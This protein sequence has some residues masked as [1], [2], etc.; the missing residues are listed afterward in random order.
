MSSTAAAHG[1]VAPPPRRVVVTGGSGGIGREIVRRFVD[2]GCEVVNLDRLPPPAPP[3]A[4]GTGGGSS[5]FIGVDLLDVEAIRA[6]FR[7]ADAHFQGLAPDVL[8]CGAAIGLTQHA[9]E[10]APEDMDRVMGVNVRGTF[11]CVQESAFRMRRAGAGRIVVITSVSAHQAW[12]QE[13]LYNISKAAQHALVQTMAVELAPFN[14]QVNAVAPGVVETQGQ[15]MSGNRARPD[16]LRHYHDIIPARRFCTPQEVAE[17]T[18]VLAHATYMTGQALT[19]DG[20]V[21]ANGLAY[22]GSLRDEVLA[23]LASKFP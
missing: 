16:V 1:P 5:R 22:I 18:W 10:V 15:G 3:P 7:E 20:G 17:A 4:V 23:R 14:I 21:L 6:A 13:P 9:L 2:A 11:F 12:A 19:I 8:V